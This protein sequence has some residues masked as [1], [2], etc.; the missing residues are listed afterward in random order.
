MDQDKAL[1][2]FNEL[3][4]DVDGHSIS[5]VG[6]TAETFSE[7]KSFVYGEVKFESFVEIL[8]KLDFSPGGVFCDLGSGTGKAVFVAHLMFP[9]VKAVG[10]ELVPTLHQSAM[11]ALKRYETEIK[12]RIADEVKG[13]EIKFIEADILQTD[14]SEADVIF[15][16]STCFS[17]ELMNGVDRRI[18]SIKPGAYVI[19]LTKSLSNPALKL[20]KSELNDFSWGKATAYYHQRK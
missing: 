5:R 2:I 1:E 17:D 10:V 4:R 14:F 16:N 8:K 6:R 15:M 9:F 19:S 11:E 7:D 20:L 18:D 13:K 3:Y 12:P